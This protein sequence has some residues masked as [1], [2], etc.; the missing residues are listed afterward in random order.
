[1]QTVGVFFLGVQI[2]GHVILIKQIKHLYI[3]RGRRE[4]WSVP[5]LL[6]NREQSGCDIL[7]SIQLE[8]YGKASKELSMQVGQ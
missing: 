3:H 5:E 4:F 8:C 7:T 1:M 6:T 2:I